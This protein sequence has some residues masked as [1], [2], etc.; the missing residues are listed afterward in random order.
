MPVSSG[1]LI[2]PILSV[3]TICLLVLVVMKKMHVMPLTCIFL[4]AFEI[5][6]HECDD[7]L[8]VVDFCNGD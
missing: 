6:L 8:T 7:V 1:R 3:F 2:F 4:L 5:P